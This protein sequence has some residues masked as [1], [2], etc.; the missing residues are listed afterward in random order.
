MTAS[1]TT[2]PVVRSFENQP[3]SR[4]PRTAGDGRPEAS[5]VRHGERERAFLFG[6]LIRRHQHLHDTDAVVEGEPRRL[7]AEER[8]R[9]VPVLRLVAIHYRL[10]RDDGHQADLGVLLLDEIFTRPS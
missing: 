1:R 9:E 8:A 2:T 3:R 6:A 7:L 5:Q 10:G 4:T